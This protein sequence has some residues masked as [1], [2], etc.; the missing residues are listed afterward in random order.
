MNRD[1][2]RDLASQ[3]LGIKTENTTKEL[4]EIGQFIIIGT[5][6]IGRIGTLLM[7]FSLIQKKKNPNY[8]YPKAHLMVG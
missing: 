4:S 2:I 8:K 7:A 5:M 3:E 1:Q 6:F